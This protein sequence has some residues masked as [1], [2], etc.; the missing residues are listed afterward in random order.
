[1]VTMIVPGTD[2]QPEEEVRIPA[3]GTIMPLDWDA[4]ARAFEGA[5][6]EFGWDAH[7]EIRPERRHVWIIVPCVL[8][9]R[10]SK[11][12]IDFYN[13]VAARIGMNEWMSIWVDFGLRDA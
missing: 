10:V 1:M 11:T 13:S 6:E 5:N 4:V 8:R 3:G 12:T 9:N 7:F 2:E